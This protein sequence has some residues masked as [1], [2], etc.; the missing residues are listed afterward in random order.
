ME[1][2]FEFFH[3]GKYYKYT[4]SC[5]KQDGGSKTL[6]SNIVPLPADTVRGEVLL[7]MNVME[8]LP[9]GKI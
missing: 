5:Y 1:K 8:R 3:E 7:S 4:S 9:D 6:D 2:C